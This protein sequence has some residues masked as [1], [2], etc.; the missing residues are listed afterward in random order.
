M[1][2]LV[3]GTRTGTTFFYFRGVMRKKKQIF[4]DRI[5][6]KLY[7]KL[8]AEHLIKLIHNASTFSILESVVYCK[9]IDDS[10]FEY[11]RKTYLLTDED[12]FE[13]DVFDQETINDIMI[14]APVFY[15]KYLDFIRRNINES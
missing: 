10:V 6:F 13:L 7:N 2:W 5:K 11:V 15:E 9:N 12:G 4:S 8:D 1:R 14:V 3:G